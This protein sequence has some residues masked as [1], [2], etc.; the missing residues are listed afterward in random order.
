MK[1]RYAP[2]PLLFA[3]SPLAVLAQTPLPP[4]EAVAQAISAQAEVRAAGAR[5]DAA[6]ADADARR[7]GSGEWSLSS[8]VQQRRSDESSGQLHYPEYELQL[9]R[10]LRWPGKRTLDMRIGESG[11]RAADQRLD[12]ARHM[13]ARRLLQY[14]LNWLASAEAHALAQAQHAS[15]HREREALARRVQLGD[16][17]RKDL[18][19]IEVT[20][21]QAQADVLAAEAS[22]QNAQ[23]ALRHDFPELPLPERA[24]TIASPAR[25][26]GSADEWVQRI[27][28][29]SHEIGAAKAEAEAADALAERTSADQRRPD[30]SIGLRLLRE[31]DG[32]EN[33]LGLVFSMPLPGAYRRAQSHAASATARARHDDA[34]AMARDISRTAHELLQQAENRHRQWLAQQQALIASQEATRRIHRGWQLGEL[35]L[36]DWLQA[37]RQQR[38]IARSELDARLAAEHARLGVLVDSHEIWHE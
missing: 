23:L 32:K 13:A 36:S 25:L 11:Q 31:R 6:R 22:L 21:A 29:R 24:P 10:N 8:I 16:A 3:L 4:A 30:P 7:V 17:A 19:L 14:W 9:G 28:Q 5:L 35:S 37:E 38:Q 26:D 20:L 18:D 34:A 27:I 33:A 15:L 12:D 2:L 1:N